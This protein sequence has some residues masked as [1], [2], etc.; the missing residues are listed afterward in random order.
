MIINDPQSVW[1]K[2]NFVTNR[3]EFCFFLE[4]AFAITE[5]INQNSKNYFLPE[6]EKKK[7]VKYEISSPRNGFFSAAC[8]S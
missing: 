7:S 5:I 2:N 4:T 3:I 1:N 8:N 6:R